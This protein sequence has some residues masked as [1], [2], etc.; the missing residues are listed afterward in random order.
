LEQEIF[1]G[2]NFLKTV[3]PEFDFRFTK[4][5]GTG[6]NH[7][8]KLNE[9]LLAFARVHWPRE[10]N[11]Q[12]QLGYF[13]YQGLGRLFLEKSAYSR[14]WVVAASP[15]NCEDLDRGAR[16]MDWSVRKEVQPG[17]LV[18]L[19]RTSPRKA[20]TDILQVKT[21]P[22]F[23]P[24]GAWHGF[25]ADLARICPIKDIS[26]AEMQ[27]DSGL[28][29]WGIV[30]RNFVGTVT[31]PV[32]AAAYNR[33]LEKIDADLRAKH[34]LQPVKI[35]P[36]P[37]LP[38]ATLAT[39]ELAGQ[40]SLEAEFEEKVVAPLLK[41]WDF[42]YQRQQPC[43]VWITG[44]ERWLWVDFL[45]RDAD[46]PLTLFENKLRIVNDNQLE[47]AVRQAKTY[48]LLLGLP[49]FVV[50]SPEG[51]WLYSLHG[52]QEELVEPISAIKARSR[53][54]EEFRGLLLGLRR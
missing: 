27:G 39:P 43:S 6:F 17:D 10:R 7:Y 49:S 3:V 45:V 33:L 54:E 32:P 26:F 47:L 2:F 12:K 37:G 5:G 25:W 29:E 52:G 22:F 35:T 23:D 48:A 41:R 11:P 9:A 44:E 42:N 50:A 30:K 40:F 1:T 14:H 19:Y 21:E 28:G 36:S 53:Q 16:I 38:A 15:Q 18:F 51:M 46:R 24:W 31:E 20:I 4:V 34:N 13:L 8:L